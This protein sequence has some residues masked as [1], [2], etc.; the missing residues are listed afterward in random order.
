MRVGVAQGDVPQ[1]PLLRV[2]NSFAFACRPVVLRVGSEVIH[3]SGVAASA[4]VLVVLEL[5]SPLVWLAQ[6]RSRTDFFERRP[7]AY[8][9]IG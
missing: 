1:Q 2:R 5:G 4:D 6:R 7:V 3:Q 8:A 9:S